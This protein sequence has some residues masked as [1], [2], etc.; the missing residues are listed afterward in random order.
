MPS[1]FFLWFR[2]RDDFLGDFL[3]EV[4]CIGAPPVGARGASC[5]MYFEH[6]GYHCVGSLKCGCGRRIFFILL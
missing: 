2:F 5:R 1:A 4:I 3:W 6:K